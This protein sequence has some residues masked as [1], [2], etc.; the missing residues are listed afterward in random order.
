MSYKIV[1]AA[2]NNINR[3]VKVYKI[4]RASGTSGTGLPIGGLIGQVVRK[5]SDTV[6]YITE[7]LWPHKIEL[8]NDAGSVAAS[9]TINVSL[10]NGGWQKVTVTGNNATITITDW[11]A[12][13]SAGYL[14]LELSGAGSFTGLVITNSVTSGSSA[15]DLSA[16]TDILQIASRDAGAT[17]IVSQ[18]GKNYG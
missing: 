13:P 8:F 6:N 1:Q 18:V 11:D 15:L 2:K 16:G 4:V 12:I 14:T 10:N 9:A 5:A 3:I 17:V 7:W